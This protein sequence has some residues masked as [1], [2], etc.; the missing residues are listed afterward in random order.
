[1]IRR[2]TP[3][4]WLAF[5]DIR[6][7]MLR[8][9]PDAYGSPYSDWAERPEAMIREWLTRMQTFA[10]IDGNRILACAALSRAQNPLAAHRAEVIAVYTRQEARG[11]GRMRAILTCMAAEARRQGIL[12]L[13]LQVADW[14]EVAIA[15]YEQIGFRRYGVLPRAVRREAAF[16]DDI[17]MAWAL[18][19][20][21]ATLPG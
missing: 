6:L 18:D 16:G 3:A 9:E 13:E 17:L 20:D 12:Q 21:A 1:M 14:N 10:S 15:A 4:D 5:R 7:E 2:L 19:A 8:E 11:Q